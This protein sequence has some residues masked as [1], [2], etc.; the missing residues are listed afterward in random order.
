MHRATTSCGARWTTGRSTSPSGSTSGSPASTSRTRRRWPSRSCPPTTRTVPT[1][2]AT[3]RTRPTGWPTC[4]GGSGSARATWSALVKPASLETAVAYM[5]IFRMGAVAL[6]M[7][8][9]FGPDALAFRLRHGDAKA[10]ISSAENAPKVREALGGAD[11]RGHRD[12]WRRR[13]RR[14]TPT[15]TC[16]RRRAPT[17]SPSPRT[18]RIRPSSSTRRARP[19]TRRAPC[20]PTASPSATSPRSR[21][22]TSS[23]RSPATSS[24]RRPT[25]RG[26]PASWTSSSRRGS[27]ACPSSSTSTAPSA[28]SEPCG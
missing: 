4:C 16:W 12:R 3:S 10:V 24:G 7:S 18:G 19:A 17:S 14:A 25:G 1:P 15:R 8:S 2:S 23:T 21:P 27:T 26:S 5:A 9:L 20:T 22:S 28:P 11:V 13:G 6:P